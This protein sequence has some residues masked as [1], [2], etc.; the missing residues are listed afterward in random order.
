MT[1]ALTPV[2]CRPKD[3]PAVLGVSRS[4]LYR[5]ADEGKI[6]LHRRA[7]MTWVVVSEWLDYVRGSD[8]TV[9]D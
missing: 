5:L 2:T 1:A 4:Q 6:K 8:V 3:A 7:G 9:G